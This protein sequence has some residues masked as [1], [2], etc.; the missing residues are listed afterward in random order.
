MVGSPPTAVFRMNSPLR[1]RDPSGLA[2]CQLA[3]VCEGPMGICVEDTALA[4]AAS[5]PD[6]ASDPHLYSQGAGVTSATGAELD[7]MTSD[8]NGNLFSSGG[9]P[10][11]G[12]G[13]V[14]GTVQSSPSQNLGPQSQVQRANLTQLLQTI[15]MRRAGARP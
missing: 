14:P 10:P 4:D 13:S 8:P 11:T 6:A 1:M 7:A 15:L 12:T 3:D 9:A 5:A 2:S